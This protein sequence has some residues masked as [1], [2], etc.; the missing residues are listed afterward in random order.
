MKGYYLPI[1]LTLTFV[2]FGCGGGKTTPNSTNQDTNTTNQ[3]TNSTNQDTNTTNQNTNSTNQ[4]TNTT[5]QNTNST[6]QDTNTTN[7]NTNSTNQ[8]SNTTNPNTN[9]TNQDSNTTNQDSNTTNQNTNS[10]NQDTN[11]TN[12]NTTEVIFGVNT[13]RAFKTALHQGLSESQIIDRVAELINRFKFNSIRIG[14]TAS[15]GGTFDE[16]YKGFGWTKYS[17][18]S[19]VSLVHPSDPFD[20]EPY[21]YNVMALKTASK[22][23][24]SVWVD[25]HRYMTQED[26]DLVFSLIERY[27]V[28]IA[29]ITRDNEPYVPDRAPLIREAYEAYTD[30]KFSNF[31]WPA[32]SIINPSLGDQG[33]REN[34]QNLAVELVNTYRKPEES[35]EIHS[36]VPLAYQGEPKNWITTIINDTRSAYGVS[37]DKIMLGEWS[38][39][40]EQNF[41]DA[42]INEIVVDYLE[43]L[44]NEKV[45]SYYQI[46]GSGFDDVGL[47]NF[48][49]NT[50]NRTAILFKNR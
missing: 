7:P 35:I 28:K 36:Y 31:S 6:N 41:S 19:E 14:G 17:H 46:L 39:K 38:G 33:E 3:N 25:L 29:G 43:V 50:E 44:N 40:N 9:S 47:F 27:G 15:F 42:R 37:N 16:S 26:I 18:I 2:L 23:N 8:D 24:V 1:M 12:Q 48:L 20:N 49:A 10:T 34:R 5:N 4:D 13:Q 11:A 22:A 32:M 30:E 45:D 21:N